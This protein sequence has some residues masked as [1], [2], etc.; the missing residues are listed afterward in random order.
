MNDKVEAGDQLT[1]GVIDLKQLLRVSKSFKKVAQYIIEEIQKVYC[2]QGIELADKYIEIVVRKIMSRVQIIDSGESNYIR[3]ETH[4]KYIL[5]AEN[6]KLAAN[7][8]K[9]IEFIPII[10][11]TKALAIKTHS[12]LSAASFQ[13]TS[14]VLIQAVIENRTDPLYG[15]KENVIVGNMIPVGSGYHEAESL[16]EEE[17]PINEKNSSVSS[18]KTTNSDY[19]SAF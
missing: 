16:Q 17:K 14:K 19:F 13:Q 8:A 12:F 1:E 9:L 6:T 11:G 18:S 2:L 10:C 5:D 15:L 3:G 7:K 4:E